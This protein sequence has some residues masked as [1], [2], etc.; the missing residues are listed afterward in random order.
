MEGH[1]YVDEEPSWYSGP[2]YARSADPEV[3]GS[4]PIST[5]YDPGTERPSGAFRLPEQRP[6][7]PYAV[8]DPAAGSHGYPMET[9]SA[10]AYESGRIPV[11]GPEYPAV[12]P[13][14][15][16]AGEPA[17][18]PATPPAP[19]PGAAAAE[20]TSLVPPVQTE[21]FEVPRTGEGVYRTRRP[22]SLFA[23]AT[24]MVVLMIPVV[25]L[26]WHATFGADP[27]AADVVP[28]VLLALGFAM[29]G[30]GLF[31]VAGGGPVGRDAWLRPPVAYLPAGL[32]LLLAA[33]LAVA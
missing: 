14:A 31:A 20:P 22:I 23:I 9:D 17:P 4:P 3:S 11:R 13:K 32:I 29:S 24:A 19:A 6:A 2:Q 21:R 30:I 33:G 27:A 12:R 25:R 16:P 8:T 5:P 1:R 7:N 28:A 15:E 26:L 10:H 18:G